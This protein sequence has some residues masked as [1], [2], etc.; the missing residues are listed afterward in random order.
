MINA[1]FEAALVTGAGRR[2]GRAIALDLASGALAVAVHYHGSAKAA[3]AL[4]A[5]IRAAGGTAASINAD[6][7]D[8]VSVKD[9]IANASTALG[10]PIDVLV[11]NAAL[12]ENDT[13]RDFTIESWD[14]HQQVNLLAPMILTQTLAASLK[15]EKAG[16]VINMIDQRVLKLNPQYFSYTI[17]KAGLWTATRTTAQALAPNIRVNAIG[18]GPTLANTGQTPQEFSNEAASV[19]LGAGPSLA[20][21]TK[22][23][24]FL[25]ES[26]SMTGQ[27]I[28]LDGGQH[29]AWQTKDILK[30]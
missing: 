15:G 6:L 10:K 12:Y 20:E 2:I 7:Q 18:P 19:P 27:M 17:A 8:P 26:P 1:P 29:L 25:L 23:V 3:D 28:A 4:V 14:Q 22:A 24:R 5:E 21:I 9:L 16:A 11:N 13:L 30:D